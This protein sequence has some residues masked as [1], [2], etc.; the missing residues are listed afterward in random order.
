MTR[1]SDLEQH[2]RESYKL[3][4]EF[5]DILRLSDNPK[6]RARAQHAIEEQWELIKGYLAEYLPLCKRLGLT[7]PED[8]AEMVARFPGIASPSFL[9]PGPSVRPSSPPPS[10]GKQ[11]PRARMVRPKWRL[12]EGWLV[13]VRQILRDPLWQGSLFSILLALDFVLALYLGWRWF[14][15]R[16]DVL[17]YVEAVSGMLSLALQVMFVFIA[18]VVRKMSLRELLHQLGTQRLLQVAIGV[19][20]MVLVVV[21]VILPAVEGIGYSRPQPT[22]SP[23]VIESFTVTRAESIP[24]VLEIQRGGSFT[25]KTGEIATVEVYISPAYAECYLSFDWRP[26]VPGEEGTGLTFVYKGLSQ[27]G[28]DCIDVEVSDDDTGKQ[29][30][31][32]RIQVGIQKRPN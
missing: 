27:S 16:P 19:M 24:K 32:T 22:P 31:Q 11:L 25:V 2:I 28:S 14:G 1:R 21:A 15:Q 12:I 26:C 18:L 3:I 13:E 7:M 23:P 6:E 8:I 20:T 5:E 4:R 9:P 17:A 10:E 29:L 30:D